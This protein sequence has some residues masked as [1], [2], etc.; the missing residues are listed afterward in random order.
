MPMHPDIPLYLLWYLQWSGD[1]VI[2]G[3]QTFLDMQAAPHQAE[4]S[5][6]AKQLGVYYEEHEAMNNSAST[7][8]VVE[9]LGDMFNAY[10]R[11]SC[12]Q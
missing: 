7:S 12:H 6:L 3:G 9:F 2:L 4:V 10:H 1:V 8:N 11:S 5:K